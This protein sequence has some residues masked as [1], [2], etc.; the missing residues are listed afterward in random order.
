MESIVQRNINNARPKG[1][2]VSKAPSS[3][4]RTVSL[5]VKPNTVVRVSLTS[6][7]IMI[8]VKTVTKGK[9]VRKEKYWSP[10]NDLFAC[11]LIRCAHGR[12]KIPESF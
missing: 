2:R 3:Q 7:M 4:Q 6:V 8:F 5:L 12:C 1:K 9:N 10:G 11:S